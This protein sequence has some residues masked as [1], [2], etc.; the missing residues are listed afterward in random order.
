MDKRVSSFQ[1][2]STRHV[3]SDSQCYSLLSHSLGINSVCSLSLRWIVRFDRP[4]LKQKSMSKF[5]YSC[6]ES[7][8]TKTKETLLTN[9]FYC[10]SKCINLVSKSSNLQMTSSLLNFPFLDAFV[11]ACNMQ[12]QAFSCFWSLIAK[13]TRNGMWIN[14]L[15]FNMIF[16]VLKTFHKLSTDCAIKLFCALPVD[17]L[18]DLE[19]HGWKDRNIF[20]PVCASSLWILLANLISVSMDPRIETHRRIWNHIILC[21]VFKGK[22]H[23]HNHS[24]VSS[25]CLA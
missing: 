24:Q 20:G 9:T 17:E 23:P 19:V 5:S 2:A 3:V 12:P 6:D 7:L 21:Y 25:M 13:G 16:Y 15:C 14:V 8:V 11:C 10:N 4:N 22:M 1:Y 18:H